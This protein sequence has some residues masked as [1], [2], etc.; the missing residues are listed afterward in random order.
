MGG[1]LNTN[2]PA[3]VSAFQSMLISQG[4]IVLLIFALVAAAWNTLRSSQM[5]KARQAGTSGTT[6]LPT[7]AEPLGRRALRVSFGL[8]W[9]LD[10]VL[11]GQTAMPLGLPSQVVQ[12][13]DAGSPSWVVHL[14]NAGAAIWD[15]HPVAAAA[16][17]VWVQ[18]GIGLWLLAAAHG[19][20]SRLAGVASAA[21][22]LVVWI[23]GEA[24]GGIFA[25]GL[26]W[27]FGAPGGVLLYC[28][29]GL[30]L[31]L[32]ETTWAGRRVGRSLLRALGAFSLGMA[33]LQAWP[34]RGFWQGRDQRGRLV[35]QLP[36]MV[37]EMAAT[38]QP[39][40]L[41][42]WLSAFARFDAA[43]GWAVNLAVVVALVLT[44]TGLLAANGRWLRAT[45]VAT[46]VFCLAV[47][48]LVQDLGFFGG[49]G[50][51][52]NSMVPMVVLVVAG[53][54]G[55]ARPA[56]VPIENLVPIVP[57][58]SATWW[59]GLKAD[60]TY[61]LRSA[62]A[63]GALGVTLL[64]AVPMAVAAVV[65]PASPLLAQAVDGE[66]QAMNARAAAFDLT[67]QAGAPVTLASLRGKVVV[68]TFLD[69]TC[70][71]DC[72]VIASELRT[73]DGYLGPDAKRVE[74]VAI[75]AN[76]RYT[77]RAY[78]VAFD[79]QEGMQ[80][81]PN[82]RFLTGSPSSL[83]RTWKA[84]GEAVVQLPAGAMVGHSEYAWVID[85]QGRARYIIDTDPGPAT[86]ATESSFA[87]M[88]DQAV[89][90]LLSAH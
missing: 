26:T 67:D 77:A 73:A 12:P 14:V 82:W 83:S 84:Y 63:A 45:T 33:L 80:R 39:S 4:L 81:L 78:A 35:G 61:A 37:K 5:H 64:G 50:T 38:P 25:P 18:V 24:F 47:W 7:A 11:Q 66:P 34:G 48:V 75:N 55:V 3:I 13:S 19:N 79:H 36:Q 68:L 60:P 86:S 88:L 89:K 2:N 52:P 74:M 41:S 72:P 54:L 42:G 40:T 32:P 31:A 44:G 59:A 15:Y 90:H 29:A 58:R 30:L 28:V 9:V 49:L 20:W 46:V 57:P 56:P 27:L 22:G 70:T 51:D 62:A 6:V 65:N 21:W 16:A 69:V 1:P 8:L 53:Y 71:T 87:V 76:P 23:F 85:R 10:G 43:H 17:A